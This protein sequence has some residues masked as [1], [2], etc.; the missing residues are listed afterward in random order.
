MENYVDS[1]LRTDK[2]RILK[3]V[4]IFHKNMPTV[5]NKEKYQS[6]LDMK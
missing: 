1:S 5:K 4:I 6:L 3:L 2:G